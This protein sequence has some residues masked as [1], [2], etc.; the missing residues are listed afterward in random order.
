MRIVASVQFDPLD[1]TYG[2]AKLAIWTDLEPTLGIINACM[3]I[4]QPA[5]RRLVRTA[6]SQDSGRTAMS[7]SVRRLRT[8]ST[9]HSSSKYKRFDDSYLLTDR[10]TETTIEHDPKPA[11]LNEILPSLPGPVAGA[12]NLSAIQVRN[13]WNVHSE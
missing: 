10:G 9:N 5:L 2:L 3:H 4:M 11:S 6:D 1:F 8:K 7:S 13:E 12:A